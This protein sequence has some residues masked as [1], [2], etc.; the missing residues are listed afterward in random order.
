MAKQLEPG[1]GVRELSKSLQKRP[2]LLHTFGAGVVFRV[3]LRPYRRTQE[4]HCPVLVHLHALRKGPPVDDAVR[5]STDSENTLA[6][7]E[8]K[9]N[10]APGGSKAGKCGCDLA[11]PPSEAPIVEEG[12]GELGPLPRSSRRSCLQSRVQG[13]GKEQ[14]AKRV[15]LLNS[16]FRGQRQ[17]V[18]EKS[19]VMVVAPLSPWRK[20]RHVQTDL[21]QHGRPINGVERVAEIHLQEAFVNMAG[22]PLHPLPGCVDGGQPEKARGAA[23]RAHARR[24]KGIASETTP[25]F[26]NGDGAKVASPLRQSVKRGPGQVG[27]QLKGSLATHKKTNHL[28]KMSCNLVRVGRRQGFADVVTPEAG[29]AR[30]TAALKAAHG[31]DNLL[32]GNLRDIRPRRVTQGLQAGTGRRGSR[33]LV[34]KGSG[35]FG[36]LGKQWRVNQGCACTRKVALRG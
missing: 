33:V 36:R 24:C 28:G 12:K 17:M 7:V 5:P 1:L 20:P 29:G 6:G 21:A 8:L 16:S 27:G 19:G 23:R 35:N 11:G 10:L 9:T 2:C 3:V 34:L 32:R 26:T 31:F 30:G 4:V 22:V 25:G 15:A 18:E 13:Q 14:G